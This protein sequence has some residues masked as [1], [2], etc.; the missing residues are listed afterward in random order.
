MVLH[1]DHA[2]PLKCSYAGPAPEHEESEG[3]LIHAGH[4][5]VSGYPGLWPGAGHT[6]TLRPRTMRRPPRAQAAGDLAAQNISVTVGLR[7]LARSMEQLDF[8]SRLL[9][10]PSSAPEAAPPRGLPRHRHTW[11][12]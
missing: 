10:A 9:G 3:T 6:R 12:P 5:G 7:R 4:K 2:G 8:I 1:A 11:R